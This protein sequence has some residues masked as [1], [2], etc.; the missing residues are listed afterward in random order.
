MNRYS[1]KVNGNKYLTLVPNESKEIMKKIQ[2]TV[3]IKCQ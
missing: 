3:D 2:R 1:E